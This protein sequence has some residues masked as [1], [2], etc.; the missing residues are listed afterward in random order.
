LT[1]TVDHVLVRE[2]AKRQDSDPQLA[3]MKKY[4]VKGELPLY[5]EKARQL[6]LNKPQFEIIDGG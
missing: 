2:L 3:A 5:K 4:L 6:V 1:T